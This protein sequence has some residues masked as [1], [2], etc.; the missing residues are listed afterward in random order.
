M[1]RA[2]AGLACVARTN[3]GAKLHDL[4]MKEPVEHRHSRGVQVAIDV[5]VQSPAHVLL[6]DELRRECLIKEARRDHC[7]RP[8]AR[9]LLEPLGGYPDRM[10]RLERARL[11]A[12]HF[13]A[14]VVLCWQAAERVK[15]EYA[16]RL[17]EQLPEHW[18]RVAVRHAEGVDIADAKHVP[19]GIRVV[20]PARVDEGVHERLKHLMPRER[21]SRKDAVRAGP[22]TA[23]DRAASAA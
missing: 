15:A 18:Q 4:M 19:I 14:F 9:A 21:V 10:L 13:A 6:Y 11:P 8:P 3:E 16:S 17:G 7:P 20:K 2:R 22:V 5:D 1:Q 12:G 23:H